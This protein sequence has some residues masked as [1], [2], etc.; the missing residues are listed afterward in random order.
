MKKMRKPSAKLI[1]LDVL[2]RTLWHP[3]FASA[4]PAWMLKAVGLRAN[5]AS[6]F[7]THNTRV[8]GSNA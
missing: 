5:G 7:D 3:F 6:A 1:A 4:P 2:W 8:N